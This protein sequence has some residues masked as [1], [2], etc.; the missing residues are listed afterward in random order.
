MARK[1]SAA[2]AKSQLADCL[3]KAESGEAVIITR[4]GKAVAALVAVDRVAV[5]ARGRTRPGAGLASLIGGWKGSDQ[6]VKALGRVR[7]TRPRRPIA[8]D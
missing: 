8:L 6:L 1:L 2:Q 5:G 4:H 7:R 3:R